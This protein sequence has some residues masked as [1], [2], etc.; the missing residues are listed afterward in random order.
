M[1][2]NRIIGVAD[3]DHQYEKLHNRDMSHAVMELFLRLYVMRHRLV[4]TT[5]HLDPCFALLA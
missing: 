3:F 5:R 2:L 1:A 4:I